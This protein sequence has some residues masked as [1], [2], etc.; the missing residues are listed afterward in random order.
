MK[1]Y[2]PIVTV[3][4]HPGGVP[5]LLLT[6]DS[7]LETREPESEASLVV[8]GLDPGR[9]FCRHEEQGAA[10]GELEVSN[11][12]RLRV[13]VRVEFDTA[14]RER[15]GLEVRSVTILVVLAVIGEEAEEPDVREQLAIL[16]ILSIDRP[17]PGKLEGPLD[18]REGR[19]EHDDRLGVIGIELG[20]SRGANPREPFEIDTFRR[21]AS[22]E[23][24]KYIGGRVEHVVDERGAGHN[25]LP[26]CGCRRLARVPRAMR[27]TKPAFV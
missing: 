9:M 6:G 16:V 15:P 20:G 18:G 13:H 7:V 1:P 11:V 8:R 23:G 17:R 24:L 3:E 14:P 26:F 4:V 10:G 27:I 2:S 5:Q 22:L 21:G 25:G 19:I 12:D